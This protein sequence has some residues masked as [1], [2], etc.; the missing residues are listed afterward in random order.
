MFFLG[1]SVNLATYDNLPLPPVSFVRNFAFPIACCERRM[2]DKCDFLFLASTGQV[3]K[4][5]DLLLDIFRRHPEWTLHVCSNFHEETDFCRAF[6]R[7]LFFRPNIIAHGFTSLESSRFS[8]I[9]Q[10]CSHLILPSCSEA[11][12]G[13]VLC[14]MAAGLIPIVSEMCG[15]EPDEVEHLA[16]CD[17]DTIERHLRAA[18]ELDGASRLEK[19]DRS[20]AII[21]A[22]YTREAFVR[23]LNDAFDLFFAR[24]DP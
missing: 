7:D 18:V 3:H 5:L 11:N 15:F 23:S 6:R 21:R 14:G 2:S 12:A 22:R 9:A 16:N 24:L 4:G 13:S 10:S 19:S 8:R 1:N 17:I 20:R